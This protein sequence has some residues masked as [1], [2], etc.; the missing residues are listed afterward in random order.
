VPAPRTVLFTLLGFALSTLLALA[1]LELLLRLFYPQETLRPRWA[2]SPAYCFTVYPDVRMV[3][4]RPGRWRFV[5]TT[6]ADR[7][8]GKLV[9]LAGGADESVIV[10]LG[11]SYTFGAG[12]QDEEVYSAVLQKDLGSAYR[13]INL[14]IGGWGLT[15]EIRRYYE[16][17]ARFH[18]RVV[19]LQ[20]SGNDPEDDLK[21]PVTV[22]RE[23]QFR[24]QESTQGIYRI[25]EVLSRS[26]IQE[27]QIYNLFRD[28]IYRLL[29]A[30]L[31]TREREGQRSAGVAPGAGDEGLYAQLLEAFATDLHAQGVR[32]ILVSV[33]G[34]LGGFP[35]IASEA[36]S[37]EG[38]GLLQSFDAADWLKD[39]RDYA[40]PE[41][42]LWGARAHAM[43]G[44]RLAEIV[45]A[46]PASFPPASPSP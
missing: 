39:I 29:A 26:I 33:N 21:C 32:L 1:V 7:Y 38:K 5:Y 11:D 6:N 2:Y 36:L 43:I 40:S 14:G 12:V 34:Q 44:R 8:R 41:G 27:S 19:V 17:G 23:G 31:V 46:E 22:L 42:H 45:R 35:R 15:Q 30:R 13:V 20:F 9:P 28:R 3:H 18:P 24:F 16:F 10:I 4:E 25:K 37:L